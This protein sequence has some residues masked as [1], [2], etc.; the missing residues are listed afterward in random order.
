MPNKYSIGKGMSVGLTHT[1]LI[2]GEFKKKVLKET[3]C[4]VKNLFLFI[5]LIRVQLIFKIYLKIL[6]H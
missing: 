6:E 2:L 5:V 3:F 4:I 1:H